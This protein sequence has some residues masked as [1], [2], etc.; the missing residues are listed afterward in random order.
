MTFNLDDF[1]F[2]TKIKLNFP[3]VEV[4]V[5]SG[6][7]NDIVQNTAEVT[8]SPP[9]ATDNSGSVFL[10][11]SH[12]P[13]SSF[14]V[15]TTTVSYT[16]SDSSNNIAIESFTVTIEGNLQLNLLLKVI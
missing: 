12:E 3:D 16:A 2:Y 7:P 11:T 8:W 5:I 9:T 13:R 1:I 10:T 4:P 15:G 14:S 6:L